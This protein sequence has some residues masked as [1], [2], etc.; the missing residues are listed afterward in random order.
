MTKEGFKA[1]KRKILAALR[2]GT[3]QHEVSRSGVAVKNLL[4]TGQVTSGDICDLI[5]RSRG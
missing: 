4:L 3:Y 5:E 2:S 1:A